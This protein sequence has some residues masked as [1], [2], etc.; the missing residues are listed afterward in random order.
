MANRPSLTKKFHKGGVE[1]KRKKELK[2]F[3]NIQK[4]KEWVVLFGF[5]LICV[6]AF[7]PS[8]KLMCFF[9]DF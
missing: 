8:K 3:S 4:L 9:Y 1:R 5:D 6:K 2:P 7:I